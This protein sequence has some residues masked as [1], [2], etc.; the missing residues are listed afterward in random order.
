M[1]TL[2]Q[3]EIKRNVKMSHFADSFNTA[4]KPSSSVTAQSYTL[5]IPENTTWQNTQFC[6]FMDLVFLHILL[7]D[8]VSN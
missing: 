5:Q 1:G 2:K 4:G 8:T 3:N 6:L 7:G